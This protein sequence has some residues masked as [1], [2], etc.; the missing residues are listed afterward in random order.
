MAQEDIAK[1][2]KKKRLG[3]NEEFHKVDDIRK[4]LCNIGKVISPRSV[5]KSLEGLEKIGIVERNKKKA[6]GKEYRYNERC[7]NQREQEV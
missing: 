7:I 3:A 6:W 5:Y 4:A 1:L 2:L